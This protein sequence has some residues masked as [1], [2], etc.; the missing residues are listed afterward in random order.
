MLSL[1][2]NRDTNKG[3][4]YYEVVTGNKV[5]G[6]DFSTC[7]GIKEGSE[8]LEHRIK[9]TVDLIFVEWYVQERL[10]YQWDTDRGLGYFAVDTGLS[11]L[12][13]DNQH[14]LDLL[15][16]HKNSFDDDDKI[17]ANRVGIEL[18]RK[19]TKSISGAVAYMKS[20]G[21]KNVDTWRFS[22]TYKF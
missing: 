19:I 7:F 8:N 10:G 14:R 6:F 15:F 2:T 4:E 17:E 9:Y 3:T 20:Y 13:L 21:D 22:I 16:R 18:K 11:I 1:E 5:N 12:F